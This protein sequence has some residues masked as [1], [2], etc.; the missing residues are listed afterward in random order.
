MYPGR[1]P[2]WMSRRYLSTSMSLS[3]IMSMVTSHLSNTA[4]QNS[5]MPLMASVQVH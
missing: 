3:L 2:T 5:G 4:S 1:P